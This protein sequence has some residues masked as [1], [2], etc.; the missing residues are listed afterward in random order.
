MTRNRYGGPWYGNQR[1]RLLFE[2]DVRSRY[3]DLG[4]T[5]DK[6]GAAG[7][8]HYHV[9]LDV[10]FYGRRRVHIVVANLGDPSFVKVYAEDGPASKHR[11]GDGSL[12]MWL[13]GDPREQT[14]IPR[15]GL[16]Q[17]IGH[18]ERHLFREAWAAETGEWPGEEAPHADK[19]EEKAVA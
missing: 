14:W 8:V 18:V 6:S 11:Y 9:E 3:P 16:L 1:K 4:A 19:R 15:D 13:P 10:P 5:L 2:R 17:L 7:H 12:C